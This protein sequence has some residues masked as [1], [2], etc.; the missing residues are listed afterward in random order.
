M[1][2]VNIHD[3]KTH[4]SEYLAALEQEEKIILCRR[5]KAIAMITSLPAASGTRRIGL[6]KGRLQ[7]PDTFFDPLPPELLAAFSGE[8]P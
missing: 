1:L 6:E 3:A 2:V 8:N 7:V 5:N 4:L